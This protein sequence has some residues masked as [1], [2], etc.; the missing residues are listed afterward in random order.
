MRL[1]NLVGQ[2]FGR[3]V[4][5]QRAN[6]PG[7]R[8]YW[9]CQCDC[10]NLTDV[11]ADTLPSGR[12]RSCGCLLAEVAGK[13]SLKH[14]H[15]INRKPT[16]EYRAWSH[17]KGRCYNP[18]DEKYPQYGGRGIQMSEAWR[19]SFDQ[20]YRDMGPRPPGTTLDR[21]DVNGHYEP[22]NCRWATAFEQMNNTQR[23]VHVNWGGA[24][25]TLKQAA[26]AAGVPY[27]SLH[28]RMKYYG[29]TLEAAVAHLRADHSLPRLPSAG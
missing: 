17:A 7:R 15:S 1:K 4:V 6:Q 27:K 9:R 14:G 29:Q 16:A 18:A 5:L 24:R 11:V 8:V 19:A 20:F 26:T 10:G 2:R 12:T 25:M 13:Q 21:R 3:L 28:R 23:C 22:G